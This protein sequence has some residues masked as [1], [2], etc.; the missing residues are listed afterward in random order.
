MKKTL[1]T[2]TLLIL[3]I[4]TFGQKKNILFIAVDDLKPTIG[5][6]GDPVAKTPNIDK[7][8]SMG[9]VFENAY[10]QQ[11][12][13]GPSRASMLTGWRPDRTKVWDLKT[14]IRSKNPNVVTLPQHFKNNG[15][16]TYATGKIF[17]PRSVDKKYDA[18]SWSLPYK[19]PYN[20]PHDSP[21]PV[22]GSYQSEQHIAE[23]K[24][25]ENLAKAQGLSG[26][27]LDSYMRKH[28]KPSTEKA[29]V[30]DDYYFDGWIANDAIKKI[31]Q[32]AKS[33]KPFMLM[34]GFKKPHLPFVA[35]AKYWDL[36][37]DNEIKLAK[38]EKHA[39][40]SPD[41]AYHNNPELRSYTDIPE[42]FDQYGNLDPDKQ[43]E[44][45][46]GYYA[47]TSYIDAL[48]GRVI[49][50]LE[51][52]NL[53]DNTI[54]VLWGDH[55]FHLGDHGLWTKHT[56]FEQATRLPL[57]IIDPSKKPGKTKIPVETLD[58]FPTLCELAGIDPEPTLQGKS[59]VPLL[60]QKDIEQKYAISQWPRPKGGMGYTIRT[61][62][63]RY[64]EWYED[65]V[66][67]KPRNPKKLIGRELYDYQVD[68]LETKSQVK[69]KKYAEV[70]KEHEKLLHDFLDSQVGTDIVA[71]DFMKDEVPGKPNGTPIREIVAK[72]FPDGNVY[73]GATLAYSYPQEAKNLLAEQF[74]YTTPENAA[75]QSA[76]HP[77]PG[78]WRWQKI[79]NLVNFAEKNNIVMRLHGPIS[80]QASKWAKEDVRTGE[81]LLPVMEEYMTKQ[82]KRFNG[83][84]VIKWMDV[85]NETVNDDGS[86][87]GPKPG[88]DKWENPWLKIGL[89]ADGIPVYI[90]KAFEIANKYAPDIKLVYNQHL[91]MQ[92]EAWEKVKSTI[93]YLKKKGL[94]VD[95]IGWQAHLRSNDS[96]AFSKKDLNYLS[97]LI[98]WAHSNGL[99]FHVTEIDYRLEDNMFTKEKAEEQA[100]AY[101]NILKV[102][103]SKRNSGVVTFNTWGLYDI[104]DN[105]NAHDL[106]R[107]IFDNKLR[108]KPAFYALQK[109]LENPDDLTLVYEKPGI[110]II[111]FNDKGNLL[112]NGGFENGK[113]S[114]VSFGETDALTGEQKSGKFAGA[115]LAD[116]SGLKQIVAVKP[117]TDYVLSCWVKS[118]NGEKVRVKIM[119]ENKDQK[120][121]GTVVNSDKFTEVKLK[122]NSG[123]SKKVT[124]AIT[125]WNSGDSPA[126]IDN[127]YL[128]EIKK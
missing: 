23:Y 105:S 61:E 90:V 114:W 120:E 78:V 17:D 9:Y 55:G 118:T 101:S 10:T 6:Y 79:D 83:N 44:L 113:K 92:P 97:N 38:F 28:Y 103:L 104:E 43:K 69:N 81:E 108:A 41:V 58:I 5:A 32:F 125:K 39:K 48:I 95:G 2:L 62:R 127:V 86:W 87:F 100:I 73:V 60:D 111:P 72:N 115:L 70:L 31:D 27:K 59:L 50:E 106:Y 25:I 77:E 112:K 63:Y 40:G 35:P 1:A 52:Q 91:Q 110:K 13:C 82:C 42:A 99:E 84:K 117:N 80:P 33:N 119:F 4:S 109:V 107:F 47:A 8:A 20:L 126:W 34:V 75:K 3:F 36:Y 124:V 88:T 22:L 85:V 12:V 45:I 49:N 30:P 16:V 74:S 116:K 14:L 68:P 123:N 19:S 96:V 11:A 65:Y 128:K 66:A 76:V 29:D 98:D 121:V 18:R 94:R 89:N 122:F 24:F 53:L 102:L 54:I 7:L 37:K 51:K 15:Y 93:L 71:N 67:T 64:T 21:Y 26:K 57:L 56:N 46:H